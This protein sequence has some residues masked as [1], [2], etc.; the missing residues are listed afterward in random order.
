[1]NERIKALAVQAVG[2]YS[3]NDYWPFFEE[4]LEKFA[5]SII[6]ECAGIAMREDHDSAECIKKH[7]GVD[8]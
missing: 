2:D 5:E 3:K 8:L 7:F 4:E 1:M 6:L